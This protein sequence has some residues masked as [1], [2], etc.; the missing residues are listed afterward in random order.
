MPPKMSH[1]KYKFERV[2]VPRT[3]TV[4]YAK[5]GTRLC[6]LRASKNRNSSQSFFSI[7]SARRCCASTSSDRRN[8]KA[9]SAAHDI[10]SR[11]NFKEQMS[12][13]SILIKPSFHLCNPILQIQSYTKSTQNLTLVKIEWCS[14]FA[15]VLT[16][17][18]SAA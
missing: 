16:K 15:P 4:E 7:V 6:A 18:I 2:K 8:N 12:R 9:K 17:D 5:N 13:T 11:L 3:K 1:L 14:S 10:L